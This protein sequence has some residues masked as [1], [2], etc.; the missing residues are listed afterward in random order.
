MGGPLDAN[1]GC[2]IAGEAVALEPRLIENVG[3]MTR[4]GEFDEIDV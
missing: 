3:P 2:I 1:V 4:D